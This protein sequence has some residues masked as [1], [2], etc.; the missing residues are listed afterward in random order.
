MPALCRA[1][2]GTLDLDMAT[3]LAPIRHLLTRAILA[4]QRA[5]EPSEQSRILKAGGSISDG[6]VWGALIPSRTL[7]DFPWKDKGPGLSAEPDI[8][9]MEITAE[10]KYLILGS[11]GVFDVLSNKKIAQIV[12]KMSANAQKVVNELIKELRKKPGTDDV[13]LLVVQLHAKEARATA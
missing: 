3:C 8:F 13:T 12:C 5:T 2:A 6:R 11:D 10:D 1:I 9:E 7:G 4:A